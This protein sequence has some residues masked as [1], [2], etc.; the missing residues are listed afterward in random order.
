[1]AIFY[2]FFIIFILDFRIQYRIAKRG[3]ELLEIGGRMVYSTCSL[4]PLENEA[5]VHRLLAEAGDSVHLVDGRHL[6]PGLVC[7]P[8]PYFHT[9]E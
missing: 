2:K 7:N 5:V 1:M 8:G 3:L 6:V 4:N 9:F